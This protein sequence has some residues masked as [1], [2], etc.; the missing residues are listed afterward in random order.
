[1]LHCEFKHLMYAVVPCNSPLLL[2][3][4]LLP[5][6]TTWAREAAAAVSAEGDSLMAEGC[7][8]EGRCAARQPMLQLM[9]AAAVS[10]SGENLF[11]PAALKLMVRRCSCILADALMSRLIIT[12]KDLRFCYRIDLRLFPTLQNNHAGQSSPTTERLCCSTCTCLTRETGPTV[13][14]CLPSWPS[15]KRYKRGLTL[16]WTAVGR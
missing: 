5:G 15:C 11:E 9:A 2:L 7:E 14:G 4:L 13:H 16:Y 3:L 10:V 8:R 12:F 1:M 6:V